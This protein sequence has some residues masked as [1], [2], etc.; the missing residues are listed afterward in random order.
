MYWDHSP[1]SR[2][3]VFTIESFHRLNPDWKIDLYIPIQ[4]YIGE[5][6]YIPDY[7]YKDYFKSLY[8]LPY[9]HIIEIDLDAFFIRQD[10]H[11]ILRSDILRYHLLYDHGGVWSDFDVIWLRPMSDINLIDTVGYVSIREMGAMVTL[12]EV[13]KGYHNIGVLMSVPN[14][15]MYKEIID[16]CNLIQETHNEFGHQEFGSEML[17]NLLPD[18]DYIT[19]KYEDVVGFPYEAFAPYSIFEMDKLYHDTDMTPLD[20]KNVIGLHWFNGHKFSKDYVNNNLYGNE[21]SMTKILDLCGY[22]NV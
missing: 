1:M 15:P 12:Y 14:H 22:S 7:T 10:L 18:L 5:S 16:R 3:Q 19:N 2:L 21:S 9:L 13:T 8:H 6:R 17:N 11:N 20:N 4:K